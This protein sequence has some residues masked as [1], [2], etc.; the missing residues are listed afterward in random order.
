MDDQALL[1]QA[2]TQLTRQSQKQTRLIRVLCILTGIC[3]LFCATSFAVL[4]GIAPRLLT[5]SDQLQ[6]I[7][8]D[9]SVVS[10]EFAK[11]DLA[12]MVTNVDTLVLSAQDSLQQI[13]KKLDAINIDS[14][15][16]AIAH[17]AALIAPLAKFF[18]ISG[19]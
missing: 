15:N 16:Q 5:L 8:Q 14:L 12:G 4:A 17:L 7:L 9:L 11:L 19:N 1:L 18:G 13:T 2:V 3:M 10:S 6:T